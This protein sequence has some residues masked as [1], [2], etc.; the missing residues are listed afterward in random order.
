MSTTTVNISLPKEMYKDVK[1]AV[2]VKRYTS[3]SEMVRDSLRKSLYEEIT[4]NGFTPVFED[5]VLESEMEP[6]E[7]DKIWETEEEI[8]KDFNKLRK[9]IKSKS[10]KNKAHRQLYKD[11]RQAL[12]R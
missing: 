5:R 10:D 7:N 6:E 3:V 11:A 12:P 1:R 2:K 8:R 9:K 4:E